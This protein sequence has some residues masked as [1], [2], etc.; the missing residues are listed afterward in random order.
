MRGRWRSRTTSRLSTRAC[1]P[2]CCQWTTLT[3][4]HPMSLRSYN[5]PMICGRR[6]SLSS[7]GLNSSPERTTVCA[8]R[9]Y[10]LAAALRVERHHTARKCIT[11]HASVQTSP[12][13][14][15]KIW[16]VVNRLCLYMVSASLTCSRVCYAPR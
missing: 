2:R 16:C 11:S 1:G 3:K 13:R 15:V 14:C 9:L 8:V 5:A 4:C 10:S 12:T 7:N 6:Q